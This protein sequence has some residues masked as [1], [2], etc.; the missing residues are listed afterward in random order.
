M[1]VLNNVLD[2][3]IQQAFETQEQADEED[4]KN[5][6]YE[7]MENPSLLRFLVDMRGE[8]AS[9]GQ[10]RDDLMTMLIAGHETTAAVLTW[11]VYE[12]SQNPDLLAKVRAEIDDVLGGRDPTYDDM[13]KFNLLRL[14]IAETLRMYPEPPY[15]IRRSL[16]ED[17]LPAGGAAQE[18]TIPKGTDVLI[19]TWN[20]HRSDEFWKDPNVYNP[21]RFLTPLTNPEQKAWKG[22]SPPDANRMYPIESDADYAFMPFGGGS[23]RCI[24]DQFAMME[25][26][27]TLAIVL[28]RFDLTL[29]S[30]PKEVGMYTGATIHTENGLP[31]HITRRKLK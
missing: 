15:L 2:E 10:L 11:T 6:D 31:M 21:F 19:S 28:Q 30:D 9:C 26:I 23:R 13:K 7:N 18:T 8:E 20:L 16:E 3:L 4:L 5:R 29:A 17:V 14:C 24:G 25:A 22:Y 27:A 12:L 1:Q